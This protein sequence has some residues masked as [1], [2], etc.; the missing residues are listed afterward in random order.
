MWT[1][2]AFDR[3]GFAAETRDVVL[4]LDRAGVAVHLDAFRLH[5]ETALRDGSAERLERLV[6]LAHPRRFVQVMQGGGDQLRRHPKALLSVGRL[7]FETDRIPDDWLRP[8]GQM[9]EVWV[10]SRFNVETFSRSGV[11]AEKLHVVPEG[12]D[13]GR[14]DPLPPPLRLPGLDGFVF[15]SVFGWGR[16]KGWDVLVRAFVEEFRP[17][18]PV[19]LAIK[20]WPSFG[21]TLAD[22]RAE[23]EQYVRRELDC[24]LPP[25]VRVLDVELGDDRIASV[26][27]AAS[28]F[29]VPSRGEGWGR[30]YMEAMAAG[31]PTIGT[32]WSGN[33]AFMN[34]DN[35]YLLD[36]ALVDVPSDAFAE[37]ASFGG[38]RWAEPS[39]AHLRATM[40]G[41]YEE[42]GEASRKGEQARRDILE[43]FTR[44]RTASAILDRLAAAGVRLRRPARR[45]KPVV[46]ATLEGPVF[47][48]FGMAHVNRDLA[49]GLLA[50]ERVELE[51]VADEPEGEPQPWLA[52]LADRAARRSARPPEVWIRHGWPPDF[53]PPPAGRLVVVQPW[54]WGSL[55]VEWLEPLD[56]VV[57]EVWVPS[58]HVR[59][60]FVSSGVDRGRVH[61][62]PNGVDPIRFNRRALPL[63]LGTRKRFRFLF[64]GGTLWRK[65]ADLLLRA[66]LDAFDAGDDVCLVVKDL[67]AQSFYRGQTL[68]RRFRDLAGARG[69]PEIVYIGHELPPA[70]MPSLYAACDV[71]VHP[72]RA[73]GFALPVA[74]A[75]ACGTPAIVTGHGACLDYCDDDVAYLV[76]AERRVGDEARV[77][78]LRTLAPPAWAEPDVA[79][80]ADAMRRVAE[81]PREAR[82][83][84]VAASEHVLR[85]LTWRQ[86]A[87]VA[88][89]RLEA[90][91]RRPAR[92]VVR[93][94]QL[95]VCMIV[96]DEEATLARAVASVDGL[97]DGLVVVDTGSRDGT[98]EVARALGATVGSFSWDDDF[99]AARNE[100]LRHATKDWILVLDADQ[101][102][103]PGS[104]EEVARLLQ[105]DAFRGYLVRQLSYLEE[106]KG[107]VEHLD[108]RL[109]PNHPALRY[110]GAVHEQ[111]VCTQPELGFERLV[112]GVLVHHHGTR[113]YDLGKAERDRRVLRRM[114][115]EDPTDAF[116]Y[117][118][119]G[120]AC[121]LLGRHDEAELAFLRAIAL[122]APREGARQFDSFLLTAYVGLA[123]LQLAVERYPEAAMSA[124]SALEL[125]PSSSDARLALAEAHLRLGQAD[126]A[127]AEFLVA[128]RSGTNGVAWAP[129][130]RAP[131][132][133]ELG[134]AEAY[135]MLGQLDA[136]HEAVER[137]AGLAPEN[138]A[139]AGARRR[140][141]ELGAA[142]T[143]SP[144][145]QV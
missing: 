65:G 58:R 137:A 102:L 142:G 92:R 44:E 145:R 57:D 18:E 119:L 5:W 63:R 26:Y 110:R 69:V 49:R 85:T 54:E 97:A 74:E 124:A 52:A 45:R 56:R 109:F 6:P 121:A 83:R 123:R 143:G 8:I 139:V 132:R 33:L 7:M 51:L 82:Q 111:L 90:L 25:N 133:A 135:A 24:P 3:G 115:A 43:G 122:A 1:G 113:S 42:R 62:V 15:L 36:Y 11:P 38:H 96:R 84:G 20:T 67:G 125:M 41:V 136:A 75:M 130:V 72:Y 94:K 78:H 55:P 27:A 126:S 47:R 103:D 29:V 106:G 66:Y 21:L 60:G 80:L 93:R 23:L 40:R 9:D 88:A 28:A 22:H 14:F 100:S 98:V 95:S 114:V 64:V 37:V 32:R 140:L 13:A 81:D 31:R 12:L 35:S 71:L 53:S 17:D 68:Q 134:V 86:A 87:D 48:T 127:L 19:T 2:F 70:A 131:W 120:T 99:A 89:D 138:G 4:A 50:T 59:D 73:E 101:E 112:C 39:V 10:P 79:A 128:A 34:D 117:T 108:L 118:N 77:S 116:A 46:R 30:T 76:P 129:S 107:A 141:E 144:L 91:A 61:V 16:R 105:T 104:R